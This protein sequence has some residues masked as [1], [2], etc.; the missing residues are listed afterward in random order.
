MLI[1]RRNGNRL[2]LAVFLASSLAWLGACTSA[3]RQPMENELQIGPD[4]IGGVVESESGGEAGV[5]VIAE[6]Y[7]FF[8]TFGNI[9]V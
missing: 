7:C 5:W 6:S 9:F 4:D 1:V 2:T 3:S 8:V